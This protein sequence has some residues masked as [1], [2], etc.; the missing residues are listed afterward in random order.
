VSKT[1]KKKLSPEARCLKMLALRLPSPLRTH[2]PLPGRPYELDALADLRADSGPTVMLG[3]IAPYVAGRLV[4]IEH[5]SRRFSKGELNKMVA[6]SVIS[7]AGRYGIKNGWQPVEEDEASVLL[8][9]CERPDLDT[10]LTIAE[11]A[12]EQMPG[13]WFAERDLTTIVFVVLN[14]LPV[15]AE[16][17]TL[18]LLGDNRSYKKLRNIAEHLRHSPVF[19]TVAMSTLID[20]WIEMERTMNTAT[21]KSRTPF[22]D[23][24]LREGEVRGEANGRRASM[25]ETAGLLG[26]KKLLVRSWLKMSPED[27]E[28]AARDWI[29]SH[30]KP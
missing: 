15:T 26:A 19:N 9:L 6:K 11:W 10:R 8:V 29:L 28:Q 20:E 13:V 17:A 27:G 1:R 18:H 3:P 2:V 23:A 21:E 12:E 16:T 14:A 25:C 4:C 5:V 24:A 7:R 22:L 30:R